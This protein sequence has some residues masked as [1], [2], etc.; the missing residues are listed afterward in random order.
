MSEKPKQVLVCKIDENWGGAE[1]FCLSA[2]GQET[3]Q[4]EQWNFWDAQDMCI[5]F[6]NGEVSMNFSD[7]ECDEIIEFFQKYKEWR[8]NDKEK[9]IPV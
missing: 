6:R 2:H 1:F 4:E 5:Q 9:E 7:S 3:L 8:K